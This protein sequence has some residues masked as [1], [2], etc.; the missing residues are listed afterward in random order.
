MKPTFIHWCALRL[1][2][3]YP[4]AWRARY[5]DEV[6][7]VLEQRPATL[8]TVFDLLLGI[9][10]AYFHSELFTERKFVMLQRLRDS[11]L[12]IYAAF[13]CC[14]FF[15]AIYGLLNFY[16]PGVPD[17]DLT[18]P[19]PAYSFVSPLVWALGLVAVLSTL[20]GGCAF[21]ARALKQ[22]FARDRRNILPFI[23][24]LLSM[25]IFM[26]FLG[27]LY[28]LV[29][30]Y[31]NAAFLKVIWELDAV[32]FLAF[33]LLGIIFRV[34]QGIQAGTLSLRFVRP[35]CIPLLLALLIIALL[36]VTFS[37]NFTSYAFSSTRKWLFLSL[38]LLAFVGTISSGVIFVA[39]WLRRVEY[40]QSFLRFTLF[41][42]GVTTCALLVMSGLLL[43]ETLIIDLHV[44]TLGSSLMRV[45]LLN[46]ITLCIALPAVI[47]C[48]ALRRG[49]HARRE[50][51]QA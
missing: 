22:S 28:L 38:L 27:A 17:Y 7:A 50:L 26:Q 42:A 23:C 25:L 8:R 45:P 11:Q 33:G 32:A 21:L 44:S 20:L 1:L 46:V 48:L 16:Q 6:A 9:F 43:Y 24:I 12:V 3:F 2:C 5:V 31:M 36:F 47:A 15:W 18:S 34:R 37:P 39:R 19:A 41:F 30:P 14:A 29:V 10:D 4:R 40:S 49:V 51:Q 35:V 13:A